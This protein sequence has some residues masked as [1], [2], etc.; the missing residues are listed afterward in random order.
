MK[1]TLALILALVMCL[2]MFAACGSN[3]EPADT[4]APADTSEPKP[5]V[6]PV[7]LKVGYG[8]AEDTVLGIALTEYCE[9]VAEATE[10]A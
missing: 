8:L 3:E 10:A 7:T 4:S 1:K 9:K 6:D 5:A 2:C